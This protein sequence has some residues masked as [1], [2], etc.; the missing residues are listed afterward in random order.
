[1]TA[2]TR[3]HFFKTSSL[4]AALPLG[5]LA[6]AAEGSG[7]GSGSA[8]PPS[9][10]LAADKLALRWLEGSAPSLSLGQTLGLP[11]PKGQVRKEQ[12]RYQRLAEAQEIKRQELKQ[13]RKALGAISP[14][15]GTPKGKVLTI[16]S[17]GKAKPNA[18]D[19]AS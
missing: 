11:W 14:K 6:Q 17:G 18:D 3:R 9:Q 2:C 12:G 13:L 15:Q 19:S 8:Q 16:T 4:A 5:S 1:M 10:P 7:T